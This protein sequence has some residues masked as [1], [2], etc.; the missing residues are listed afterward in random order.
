MI[1]PAL[2]YAMVSLILLSQVGVPMHLH[3]CRGMLESV[4]V[5]ISGK[6]DD[7]PKPAA[8]ACCKAESLPACGKVDSKCCDDKVAVLLTEI[9]SVSPGI[10]KWVDISAS[11]SLTVYLPDNTD[12]PISPLTCEPIVSDTGPPLYLLHTALIFYA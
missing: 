11:A 1:R 8:Q 2:S 4:S 12:S 9:S 7:R 10:P 3:Y 6:C 5:F